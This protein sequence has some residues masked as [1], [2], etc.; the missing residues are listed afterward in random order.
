MSLG[1]TPR[2]SPHGNP[3]LAFGNFQQDGGGTCPQVSK[4]LTPMPINTFKLLLH[5]FGA[6]CPLLA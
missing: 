3:W 6:Q 1:V 5:R 2:G 4:V